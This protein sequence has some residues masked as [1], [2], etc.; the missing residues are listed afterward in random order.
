V[1]I[2]SMNPEEGKLRPQILDRFGLR[3]VVR[4]LEGAAE[5]LEAYRRV[6]AYLTNPRAMINL[7]SEE[8]NAATVELQEA[9]K[10]LRNVR[11]ED[12]LAHRAIALIQ[13]MGID[14]L[15]AEITWF[16]AAR[17]YAAAD[18]HETVTANDLTTVAPMALRLRRSA[19]MNEYFDQR[20][21][22]EEELKSLL[23]KLEAPIKTLT[24]KGT[25][26]HKGK[27]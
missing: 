11:M 23:G 21:G 14:S 24:T 26:G 15:R 25:K 18:G 7:Y 6:Q 2:G 10:R 5:R 17:A 16:E 13:K 1:L 8:I 9:R 4:G 27:S 20:R 3:V 22:E 19:F 12:A